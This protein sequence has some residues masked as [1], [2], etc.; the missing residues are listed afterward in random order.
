MQANFSPSM[1]SALENLLRTNPIECR[2]R[3]EATIIDDLALSCYLEILEDDETVP[4]GQARKPLE[5]ETRLDIMRG[6]LGLVSDDV[7]RRLI[8]DGRGLAQLGFDVIPFLADR[9]SYWHGKGEEIKVAAD[10]P[11]RADLPIHAES[12][13]SKV[14]ELTRRIEREY[15]G[16]RL[17]ITPV[18]TGGLVFATDLFRG[19]ARLGPSFEPVVAR[20]YDGTQSRQVYID[21]GMLDRLSF[22]ERHVLIVD[23]ILDTGQ[24]LT[25][26]TRQINLR[27][28]ASVK[29]CVF[30]CK[31]RR[32]SSQINGVGNKREYPFE[33]DYVG[34]SIPDVFVVGYGLDYLGRYRSLPDIVILPSDEESSG[35]LKDEIRIVLGDA[36]GKWRT[37]PL[38]TSLELDYTGSMTLED[39]VLTVLTITSCSQ[40]ETKEASEPVHRVLFA[41]RDKAWHHGERRS[42]EIDGGDIG[43]ADEIVQ[44]KVEARVGTRPVQMFRHFSRDAIRSLSMGS[45]RSGSNGGYRPEHFLPI[46][47]SLASN[48]STADAAMSG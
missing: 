9:H 32:K 11:E 29:A 12:I 47:K 46:S 8:R 27:G 25:E 5:D 19:L 48:R 36:E 4:V 15:A 18:L 1:P 13:R 33:P 17:M 44:L 35:D 37:A 24:T 39:V 20:S 34:F 38:I 10:A 30:L 22:Q 42:I 45:I 28:P 2:S 23:D 3:L 41:R 26:L 16:K 6:G 43:E 14:H 40:P 7:V 31:E 21:P